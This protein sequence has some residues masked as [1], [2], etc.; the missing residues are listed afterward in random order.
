MNTIKKT[1][2]LL[3]FC[4]PL[5][6]S[7]A[8]AK[9]LAPRSISDYIISMY[10]E[11]AKGTDQEYL[12]QTVYYTFYKDGTYDMQF[13]GKLNESGDYSYKKMDDKTAS[14][15]ISYS[16]SNQLL[17]YAMILNF[18]DHSSGT[19]QESYYNDAVTA[20][21]GTFRILRHGFR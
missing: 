4:L 17:S 21:G 15:L 1:G 11:R 8:S 18:S 9:S 10:T 7:C 12:N 5:L 14:L 20:E 2:L 19:W 3:F 13:K 16:E 6:T